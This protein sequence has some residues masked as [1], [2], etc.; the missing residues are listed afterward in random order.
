[1]KKYIGLSPRE[2]E[3]A[4]L[5]AEGLLNEGIA[6]A[7][8]ISRTTVAV[9]TMA[10]YDKLGFYDHRHRD[11]RVLTTRYVLENKI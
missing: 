2:T 3:V 6:E 1:M 8:C 7:L 11:Q 4:K 5:I 10:I 9:H